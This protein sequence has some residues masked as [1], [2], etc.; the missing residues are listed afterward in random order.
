MTNVTVTDNGTD[1]TSQLIRH[2]SD[3]GST[4]TGTPLEIEDSDG[5]S[6]N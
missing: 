1:V 6:S 2:N 5:L 4:Y 3:T